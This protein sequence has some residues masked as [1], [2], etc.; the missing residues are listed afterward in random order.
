MSGKHWL[1]QG[2]MAV[3][4]GEIYSRD[5][6][7]GGHVEIQEDRWCI[8]M[9]LAA[10][11]KSMTPVTGPESSPELWKMTSVGPRSRVTGKSTK[12]GNSTQRKAQV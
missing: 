8:E 3:L 11:C 2:Q 4:R 9:S 10:V 1:P 5:F 7:G 12:R 6:R